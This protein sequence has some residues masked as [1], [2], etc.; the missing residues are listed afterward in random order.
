MSPQR[1][2]EELRQAVI[3]KIDEA[4]REIPGVTVDDTTWG[5]F[6]TEGDHEVQVS[7]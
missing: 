2:S 4:L 1:N 5:W 6:V 3:D 7:V